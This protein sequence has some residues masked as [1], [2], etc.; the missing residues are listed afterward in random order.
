MPFFQ[1]QDTVFDFFHNSFWE[2]GLFD[3]HI[4]EN[5]PLCQPLFE[6]N[7]PEIVEIK[8]FFYFAQKNVSKFKQYDEKFFHS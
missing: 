1:Q 5:F 8:K 7:F 2:L 3:S 6:N 4:N